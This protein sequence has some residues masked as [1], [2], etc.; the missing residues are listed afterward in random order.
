MAWL[1]GN[2]CGGGL[3]VIPVNQE[4]IK[5]AN[6]RMKGKGVK[7]THWH[8]VPSGSGQP[9][10]NDLGMSEELFTCLKNNNIPFT[11]HFPAD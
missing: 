6:P 4:K 1:A 2:L 10:V 11:L 3:S 7:K 9:N 5:A 8:F